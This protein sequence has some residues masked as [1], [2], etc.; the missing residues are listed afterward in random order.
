MLESMD[1]S[2]NFNKESMFDN[3]IE[4]TDFHTLFNKY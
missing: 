3:Q 2:Y 4:K 1:A